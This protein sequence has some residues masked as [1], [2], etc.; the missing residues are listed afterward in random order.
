[1]GGILSN[2]NFPAEFLYENMMIQN[3]V[4]HNAYL[5]NIE[6]FSDLPIA[7]GFGVRDASTAKEV[8]LI[9]DAVVIGSRI[10]QEIEDSNDNNLIGNIKNLM[11]EMKNSINSKAITK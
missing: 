4:I 3:N 8:A 6:K 10:V 5:H 2:I 9:S 1:M 7:V 11:T